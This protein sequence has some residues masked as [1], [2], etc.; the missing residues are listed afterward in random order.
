MEALLERQ[1][2]LIDEIKRIKSNYKK[3][4]DDRK[5]IE[6]VKVRIGNLNEHWGE[7]YANNTKLFEIRDDSQP[8]FSR[9]I[10]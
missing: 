10:F 9:N 2:V 4:S 7:F 8:Y 3:D 6:Y 5:D 1:R